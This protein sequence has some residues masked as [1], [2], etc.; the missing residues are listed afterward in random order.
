MSL[1]HRQA[2]LRSCDRPLVNFTEKILRTEELPMFR[3]RPE[4]RQSRLLVF[5]VRL[6]VG[7]H[8]A[9]PFRARPRRRIPTG[10]RPPAQGCAVRGATLG[11]ARQTQ[12]TPTGLRPP[13][14]RATMSQRRWGCETLTTRTPRVARASQPWAGGRNAVGVEKPETRLCKAKRILLNTTVFVFDRLAITAY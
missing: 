2:S 8:F 1:A 13:A 10:F 11:N 5:R 7:D 3:N 6:E 12:T 14:R 4:P 9:P